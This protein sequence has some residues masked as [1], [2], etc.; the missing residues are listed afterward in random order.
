MTRLL[1]V[2]LSV[3]LCAQ[4]AAASTVNAA[5]YDT[6]W[7]WGGVRPQPVLK[8]ARCVYV[9]QGQIEA[10]HGD[11]SQVRFLAQGGAVPQHLPVEVWLAYR[12]HTL[13]WTP[14]EYAILLAQLRRWRQAGNRVA[15]VQIDFDAHTLH[16]DEYFE[17]LSQLR[18][19]LP[20]EYRLGITGLLDWSSRADP[21]QVNR[22]RGIVDEVVVQ[23]YQGR[24]TIENYAEYLPRVS[25]LSLPF[26]IGLLQGGNWD[27][28]GYLEKSSWFRGYVV[29]LQNPHGSK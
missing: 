13:H 8:Q 25:R 23:T 19:R 29:F 6:F 7:L 1:P 17:F 18:E 14:R 2:C 21:D 26:K 12:V 4:Y 9:L 22:L 5:D 24:H 10:R 16:L 3:L 28:P 11:E 15:G 27:A 20:S